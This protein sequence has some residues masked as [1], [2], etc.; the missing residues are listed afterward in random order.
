[1]ENAND[2]LK[3]WL[4]GLSEEE[5]EIIERSFISAIHAAGGCYCRECKHFEILDTWNGFDCWAGICKKRDKGNDCFVEE[6]DFCSHGERK[7]K[8]KSHGTD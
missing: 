6:D 7:G 4:R 5:T 3:T 2:K 1:M 8:E